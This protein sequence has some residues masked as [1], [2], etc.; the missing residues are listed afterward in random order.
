VLARQ[1][2]EICC[3]SAN[4]SIDLIFPRKNGQG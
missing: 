4:N 1:I 2:D 3:S